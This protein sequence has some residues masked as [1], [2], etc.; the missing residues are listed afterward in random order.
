VP[1]IGY[2]IYYADGSVWTDASGKWNSAPSTGVQVV[3]LL[4][5]GD[6]RTIKMGLDEYREPGLGNRVK[7][8]SLISDAAFAAIIERVRAEVL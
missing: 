5:A 4:H 1:I 3:V 6:Y 7:T 8:G 2:R